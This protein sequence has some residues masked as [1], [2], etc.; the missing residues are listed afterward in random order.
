MVAKPK[1]ATPCFMVKF[2][3]TNAIGRGAMSKIW[4]FVGLGVIFLIAAMIVF[5]VVGKTIRVDP[6]SLNSSK[7]ELEPYATKLAVQ[8]TLPQTELEAQIKSALAPSY[9]GT[10][11]LSIGGNIHEERVE[12][13]VNLSDSKVS[14]AGGTARIDTPFSGTASFKAKICPLGCGLGSS[15]LSETIDISGT[16]G[17]LLK[18]LRVSPDY[19]VV[20]NIDLDL[21][22]DRAIVYLF[23]KGIKISLRGEL[24]EAFDKRKGGIIKT[25]QQ[26]VSEMDVG[27]KVQQAWTDTDHIIELSDS[28]KTWAVLVPQSVH[29]APVEFSDGEARLAV[30]IV[31][32]TQL[33]IGTRPNIEKLPL[34]PVSEIVDD[35]GF[36]INVPAYFDLSS[37][38]TYL[39]LNYPSFVVGDGN[40]QTI[41]ISKFELSEGDGRFL[42]STAFQT[43][44]LFKDKG[45]IYIW[46]EPILSADG[47]TL[48]FHNLKLTSETESALTE[49]GLSALAPLIIG[50]VSE[51]LKIDLSEYY[52][53]A[54]SEIENGL[55]ELPT[56]YGISPELDLDTLKLSEL[57]F[58]EN[59]MVTVFTVEG[60][61]SIDVS[62]Q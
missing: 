37:V 56:E 14:L 12:Y 32:D 17:V 24:T 31:M 54:R 16:A 44:G 45:R 43:S 35:R 41:T 23:G 4:K 62:S 29:I 1:G 48:V 61:L 28:P 13:A 25:I 50:Q 58:G 8:V 59:M 38:S 33:H 36:S 21:D 10:E 60:R 57:E 39:N 51:K 55:K 9:S 53:E 11:K 26:K 15:G 18:E 7:L 6:P 52:D 46:A 5:L 49:N 27:E 19:S 3:S 2:V 42:V 47:K 20:S 30:D 22:L 40:A 34:P